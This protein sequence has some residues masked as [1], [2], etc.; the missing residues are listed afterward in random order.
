MEKMNPVEYI[1]Y[2]SKASDGYQPGW[3]FEDETGWFNNDEPFKTREEAETAFHN[4]V[5]ELE[6]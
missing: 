6:R 3:Y 1:H 5:L 2:L 4:Y